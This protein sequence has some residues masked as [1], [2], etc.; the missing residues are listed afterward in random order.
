MISFQLGRPG[1]F[2]S[3]LRSDTRFAKLSRSLVSKVLSR[4]SA[5]KE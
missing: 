1:N 5:T 3:R 2:A 4:S